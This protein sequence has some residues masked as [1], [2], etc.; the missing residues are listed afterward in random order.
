MSNKT[1]EALDWIDLV[2]MPV[3]SV[4]YEVDLPTRPVFV[5]LGNCSGP[6]RNKDI[7]VCALQPDN[8]GASRLGLAE[9]D[10][11]TR[12]SRRFHRLN[13]AEINTMIGRL[14]LASA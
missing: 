13:E 9:L 11:P 4:F 2:E 3:N 7:R 10:P 8:D 5:K 6:Y 12:N 14:M 1:G